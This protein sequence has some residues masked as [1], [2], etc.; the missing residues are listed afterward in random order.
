MIAGNPVDLG[1]GGRPDI[2]ARDTA[3]AE[4][5]K[6]KVMS[7]RN[8]AVTAPYAHN[9]F[10]ATLEDIVHFYNTRDVEDWPAI[11]EAV[12]EDDVLAAARALFDRRHAVTGW[13]MREGEAEAEALP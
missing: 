11:L 4:L 12:T 5:G 10:F 1:L 9:G 13:L 3:G 8:I 6:H 7:L 2:A